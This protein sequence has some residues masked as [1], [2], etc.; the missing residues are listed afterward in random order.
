M[1]VRIMHGKRLL[2]LVVLNGMYFAALAT[3]AAAV[4]SEK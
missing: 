1:G 2:A 4:L 3:L